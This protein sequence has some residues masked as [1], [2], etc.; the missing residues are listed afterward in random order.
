MQRVN[1][2]YRPTGDKVFVKDMNFGETITREGIGSK[3]NSGQ[4]ALS[5]AD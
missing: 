4:C 5:G 1:K 2:D 3:G